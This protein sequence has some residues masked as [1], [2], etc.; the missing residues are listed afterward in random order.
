MNAVGSPLSQEAVSDECKAILLSSV[1][2][3]LWA[4][5]SMA[6]FVGGAWNATMNAALLAALDELD[7][8][9]LDRATLLDWHARY[10]WAR[11]RATGPASM[12]GREQYGEVPTIAISEHAGQCDERLMS[13]DVRG[14]RSPV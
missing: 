5:F 4:M 10:D 6:M 9:V 14:P 2:G 12:C 13:I 3:R 8:V 1:A 11:A 7:A